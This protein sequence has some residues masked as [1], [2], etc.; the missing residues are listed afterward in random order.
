MR[1]IA[2]ALGIALAVSYGIL[3]VGGVSSY[4][5]LGGPPADNA[6]A[7]PAFLFLAGGVI[8]FAS[9]RRD[10]LTLLGIAVVA[11]LV[12]VVGVHSGIPFGRYVYTDA[13]A[14]SVLGV[15]VAIGCAWLILFAYVWQLLAALPLRPKSLPWIG[16]GWMTLIDLLIEPL[17]SGPLHYWTWQGQGVYYGAPIANFAGWFGVSLILF[18]GFGLKA[19]SGRRHVLLVGL[20]VVLFFTVI[21]LA[22]GYIG[23]LLVGLLLCL[24]HGLV[25]FLRRIR[26]RTV[27]VTQ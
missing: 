12:E 19:P 14:P 16:A 15:P 3:W 18:L 8:L 27:L 26:R 17:A 6:W 20:S 1:R 23:V 4:V 11:W 24:L 9:A 10:R 13:L 5:F 22:K 25:F 2:K 7:A 21:G